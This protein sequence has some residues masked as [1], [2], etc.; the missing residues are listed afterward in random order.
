VDLARLESCSSMFRA[1]SGIVPCETKSMAEAAAHHSC[2]T[3]PVFENLP[4]R[5]RLALL[6]RCDGHWKLVLHFL[7]CLQCMRGCSTPAGA[8]SNV[9]AGFFSRPLLAN[10]VFIWRL[11]LVFILVEHLSV[12]R[13]CKCLGME[14]QVVATAGEDHTLIVNG[15]GDLY[16]TSGRDSLS[17]V[18]CHIAPEPQSN[19]RLIFSQPTAN[20]ILQISANFHHAAFV[21]ES[22]QVTKS[23]LSLKHGSETNV[24]P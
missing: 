15:K 4:S 17:Q 9:S 11:F 7:E 14:S 23:F 20:R 16:I 13:S 10:L 12:V 8:R 5:A 22:G 21:T 6:A 18:Y 19:L 3:H 2:Q 24:K 1:P